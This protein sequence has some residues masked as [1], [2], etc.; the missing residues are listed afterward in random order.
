M[1]QYLQSLLQSLRPGEV[2]SVKY[3]RLPDGAMSIIVTPIR[4]SWT[5]PA[6]TPLPPPAGL[7][8]ESG[9]TSS[10]RSPPPNAGYTES[11]ITT[12]VKEVGKLAHMDDAEMGHLQWRIHSFNPESA[13][14]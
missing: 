8:P 5:T 10:S 6:E 2:V 3:L 14:G 9:D 1:E 4:S 11:S 13:N 7:G 12:L